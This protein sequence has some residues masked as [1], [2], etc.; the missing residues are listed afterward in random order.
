M[1]RTLLT[2]NRLTTIGSAR[3]GPVGTARAVHIH[4]HLPAGPGQ[5]GQSRLRRR[6]GVRRGVCDRVD[7]CAGRDAQLETAGR[8]YVS[9]LFLNLVLCIA[10][11]GVPSHIHICCKHMQFLKHAVN[12]KPNTKHVV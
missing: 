2:S 8:Q 7:W 6:T 11:V 12:I 9:E 4:G 5:H 1:L 10:L 3:R